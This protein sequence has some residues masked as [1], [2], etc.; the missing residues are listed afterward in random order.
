MRHR[1]I[2]P[3]VK[4]LLKLGIEMFSYNPCSI[5]QLF[6][7]KNPSNKNSQISCSLVYLHFVIECDLISIINLKMTFNEE[8]H[9]INEKLTEPLLKMPVNPRYSRKIK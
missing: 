3:L 1:L 6:Q 2:S 4:A 8:E 5:H 9:L 7:Q